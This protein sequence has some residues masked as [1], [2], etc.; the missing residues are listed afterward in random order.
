MYVLEQVSYS[1]AV[2]TIPLNNTGP[3]VVRT[4][5]CCVV[6]WQIRKPVAYKGRRESK[7]SINMG[8]T[9]EWQS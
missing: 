4:D 5:N 9:Q 8:V 6:L 3:G 2:P 1:R 7:G